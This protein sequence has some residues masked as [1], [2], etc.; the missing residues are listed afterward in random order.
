MSATRCVCEVCGWRGM[1]VNLLRGAS[2]F[3]GTEM[4]GCPRCKTAEQM[5]STCDEPD[6]WEPDTS[7]TPTPAGYR[8]TCWEHYP[9]AKS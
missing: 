1:V 4:I 8:R 7:G 9:E 6:C 5:R 3:N 2:P